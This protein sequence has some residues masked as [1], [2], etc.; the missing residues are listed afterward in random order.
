[1]L[2]E[3]TYG[4]D[5]QPHAKSYA[6][7]APEGTSVG[8]IVRIPVAWSGQRTGRVVTIGSL[9][10]EEVQTCGPIVR[11]A[12]KVYESRPLVSHE[13]IEPVHAVRTNNETGEVTCN[14]CDFKFVSERKLTRQVEAC[15][16][17]SNCPN[18]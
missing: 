5:D 18:K 6:Y 7:E 16:H 8:D 1:M 13:P 14:R 12:D 10:A 3:I 11:K 9:Y 4:E 2:V 15:A 17:L